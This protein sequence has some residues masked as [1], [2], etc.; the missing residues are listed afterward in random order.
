V[1]DCIIYILCYIFTYIQHSGDVLLENLTLMYTWCK[2]GGC[3]IH[4]DTLIFKFASHHGTKT[5]IP[6]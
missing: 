1:S 5:C 2:G 3:S 6:V 4:L